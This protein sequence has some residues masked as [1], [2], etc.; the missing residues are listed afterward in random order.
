MP[1]FPDLSEDIKP[2]FFE[3]NRLTRNKKAPCEVLLGLV[4]DG[5]LDIF[6]EVLLEARDQFFIW[7]D[8]LML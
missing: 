6:V 4:A 7:D 5:D 2:H 1:A 8:F 3:G